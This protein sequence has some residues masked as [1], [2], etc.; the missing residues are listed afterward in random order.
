MDFD[1]QQKKIQKIIM[2]SRKVIAEA[3]QALKRSEYF[4]KENNIDPDQL[5]R[6][7]RMYGGPNA[8]REVDELVEKMMR[9]VKEEVERLIEHSRVDNALPSMRKKFRS[10]I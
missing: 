9:D 7:L 2:D 4:F 6:E 5:M 3:Q 10:L 8:E 1:E